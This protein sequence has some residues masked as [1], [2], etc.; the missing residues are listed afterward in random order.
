MKV[1]QFKEYYIEDN[2]NS[3]YAFVGKATDIKALYRTLTKNINSPIMGRYCDFPKFNEHKIY[4]VLIDIINASDT[5]NRASIVS[6]DYIMSM[7]LS[8]DAYDIVTGDGIRPFFTG[9]TVTIVD[10]DETVTIEE[11]EEVTIEDEEE[12]IPIEIEEEG[13]WWDQY[14]EYHC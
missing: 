7:I 2:G 10:D 9:E 6:A 1:N 4:G 3:F 5:Y 14:G 11:D 8:G 13:S 12:L